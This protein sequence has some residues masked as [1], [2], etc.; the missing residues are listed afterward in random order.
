MFNYMFITDIP[1]IARYVEACGVNRIFV[2]LERNGKFERQGHLSTVIS[3]HDPRNIEKIKLAL[4]SADLMVRVNPLF[5]GSRDEIEMVLDGGCQTIMIP[6]FH[7]LGTLHK[8]DEIINRRAKIIPLVETIEA[9]HIVKDISLLDCVSEIHIG[10]N[11]LHIQHKLRFMF[12]LISN[13]EVERMVKASIKPIG[14]GGIAHVG[15]ENVALPAELVMAE[16][17]RLNS[18]GV[19]L[20]RAFHQSANSLKELHEK[21]NFSEEL[22]K[23][24]SCRSDLLNS[25]SDYL[26]SKHIELCRIVSKVLSK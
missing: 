7:D 17:V 25:D 14:F 22:K 5:S 2:D 19:I 13:G 6:M 21:S 4:K 3:A 12:E 26:N 24:I 15:A 10:L 18:C 11:D 9:S 23:L 16:H 1:E 8:F 20:S